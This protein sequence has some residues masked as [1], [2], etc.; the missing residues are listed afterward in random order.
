VSAV[1]QIGVGDLRLTR[2][3]AS[4]V[5]VLSALVACS[6]TSTPS[7][8]GDGTTHH[9]K[10]THSTDSGSPTAPTLS[11]ERFQTPSGNIVCQ[12]FASSMTCVIHSGLVPEPSQRFCPVDWIGAFI[13]VGKYAGPAC[14]GDPGIDTSPATVVPYESNWSR[15][16][17]TCDSESSGLTCRDSSGNG[18]TLARAGWSILGKE[19]AA[20][21]AFDELRQQVLEQAASDFTQPP[22][23]VHGP[24]L[25]AGKDCD[26]MQQAF[27]QFVVEQNGSHDVPVIY[28]AC[29]VSGNWFLEGPLFPD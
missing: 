2:I 14:S 1:G 11:S 26:G 4:I 23:D 7:G 20:Q 12:S 5:V 16:G 10:P 9:P 15:S 3:V 19:A 28:E 29:Y 25:R 24:T 8:S 27:V 21:A 6:T 17:V 22:H 13:Q 18:F